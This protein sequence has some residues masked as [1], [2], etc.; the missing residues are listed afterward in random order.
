MNYIFEFWKTADYIFLFKC[1]LIFYIV[2]GTFVL[3]SVNGQPKRFLINDNF[4]LITFT[5][6][7]TLIVGTRGIKIGTDTPNYYYDFFI[8]AMEISTLRDA[9]LTLESDLL[10]TLLVW[11]TS[12]TKSFTFF[13]FV[14]ALIFNSTLYLFVR[15]FTNYGKNGSSLILFLT[16]FSGFSLLS[17]EFNIIRNG[18]AI[19]FI[20][21][22]IH[23]LLSSKYK[24]GFLFLTIAF[25]FHRTAIIPIIVISATLLAKKIPLKYFMILYFV[26]IGISAL[27]YGFHSIEFFTMSSFDELRKLSNIGESIYKIGFRLDFVLY[28]TFFLFLFF[29]FS[30]FKNHKDLFLIKLY[31][32]N[33]M[34]FFLNFY[35]PFSDRFGLYSWILIPLLLYNTINEYYTSR[36]L[37][38]STI[39]LMFYFII[40]HI[41]LFH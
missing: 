24:Y 22:A 9:L 37:Y 21:L 38:V 15:K 5:I 20:L 13:L 1:I 3:K 23:Y 7:I 32:L 41:I 8:P 35:I 39:V 19:G 33:S 36:K 17:I 6:L 12:L 34:I 18:L 11:L 10:F 30:N 26:S 28:N 31:V 2:F 27:G 16:I 14:V 29:K 4:L 40:N 25:L